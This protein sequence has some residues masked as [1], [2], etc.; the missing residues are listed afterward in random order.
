VKATDDIAAAR[1]A[2][3]RGTLVNVVARSA[4]AREGDPMSAVLS[5]EL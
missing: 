1:A 3:E 2:V 5:R 4:A